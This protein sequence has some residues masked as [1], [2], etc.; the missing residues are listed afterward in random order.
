MSYTS[1]WDAIEN[2]CDLIN[3]SDLIRD[4]RNNHYFGMFTENIIDV[5]NNATTVEERPQGEWL[6]PY[7]TNIACECSVCHLQMPI[8]DYFHFCPNCGASMKGGAE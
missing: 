7:S 4:I 3:R 8:T 1:L 2:D 6:H 5:I